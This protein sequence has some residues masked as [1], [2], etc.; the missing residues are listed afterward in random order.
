MQTELVLR[1]RLHAMYVCL[2][3]GL[4]DRTIRAAVEAGC[5]SVAQIY[6]A[7]G[8]RP[9]CGKCVAQ[10]RDLITA[11]PGAEPAAMAAAE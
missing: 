7:C 6:R 11:S 10:I 9:Q 2:C 4:S 5:R 3:T 1:E 8:E